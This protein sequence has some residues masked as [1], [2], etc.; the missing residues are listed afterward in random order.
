MLAKRPGS[1]YIFRTYEFIYKINVQDVSVTF[2]TLII[3]GTT[4]FSVSNSVLQIGDLVSLRIIRK[5]P[6]GPFY[7]LTVEQ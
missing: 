6:A 3:K 2:N 5:V 4:S 7:D 1:S